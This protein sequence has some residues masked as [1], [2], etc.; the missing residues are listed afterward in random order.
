MTCRSC[1]LYAIVRPDFIS[2]IVSLNICISMMHFH[3]R[4]IATVISFILPVE[5]Y[6]RFAVVVCLDHVVVFINKSSHFCFFLSLFLTV[7][8]L[9][10]F[11]FK[12]SIPFFKK[13]KIFFSGANRKKTLAFCVK[14]W[15]NKSKI[16]SC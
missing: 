12:K 11:P 14:P 2:C 7:V 1:R 6:R 13:T 15:Y 8:I 16:K 9:Y 3:D 4:G 5:L 10:H